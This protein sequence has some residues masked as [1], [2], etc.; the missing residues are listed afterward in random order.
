MVHS[1]FRSYKPGEQDIASMLLA[2]CAT[3]DDRNYEQTI[4]RTFNRI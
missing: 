1:L 4:S 2:S 3:D